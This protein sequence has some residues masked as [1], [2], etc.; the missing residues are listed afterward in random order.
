MKEGE[1]FPKLS[2]C[3]VGSILISH[4][5]VLFDVSVI[6]S[7]RSAAYTKT[8]RYLVIHDVRRRGSNGGGKNKWAFFFTVVFFFGGG[9]PTLRGAIG[10]IDP[11][12]PN[13][14]IF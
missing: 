4:L 3:L 10:M 9:E 2:V 6:F 13:R 1:K 7:H 12:L 11:L 5:M 8:G 14:E